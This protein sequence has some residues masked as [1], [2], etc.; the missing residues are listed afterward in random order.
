MKL[1]VRIAATAVA[2]W[3]ADRYING[4]DVAAGGSGMSPWLVYAVLAVILGLVNAF[5]K[6]IVTFFTFPITFLTLGLFL[7]VINALM[8]KL[9]AWIGPSGRLRLHRQAVPAVL[10]SVV[11]SIVGGVLYGLLGGRRRG[12]VAL[13][14]MLRRDPRATICRTA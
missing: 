5:I 14:I 7:L 8:L 6:P 4:I 13:R 10:G 9:A 12:T 1:I 11:I 3:V 2:I